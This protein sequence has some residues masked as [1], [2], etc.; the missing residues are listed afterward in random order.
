VPDPAPTKYS[1]Q[2][3]NELDALDI[4][5]LKS[6]FSIELSGEDFYNALA[7]QVPNP[8]AADL[9]RRNSRE[10]AGHARRIARAI[11]LK[12]GSDFEPTPDMLARTAINLPGGINP[13]LCAALVQGELDGDAGYRKWADHESSPDVARLLRL[14]GREESIHSGRVQQAIALVAAQGDHAQ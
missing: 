9:L 14:N 13:G 3:L 4:D 5:A 7:D 6:L 11:A 10:E 2:E 8:E 12:L 1:F